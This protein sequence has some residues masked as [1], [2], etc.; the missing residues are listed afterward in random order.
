M[1]KPFK[2]KRIWMLYFFDSMLP[3]SKVLIYEANMNTEVA[4]HRRCGACNQ[5]MET[6]KLGYLLKVLTEGGCKKNGI[7]VNFSEMAR[8]A[9]FFS[10]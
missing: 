9:N 5:N 10:L 8:P 6:I 7:G 4:E 1:S 3:Y 2:V